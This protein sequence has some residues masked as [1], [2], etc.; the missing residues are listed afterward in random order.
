M[1][2]MIVKQ[3]DHIIWYENDELIKGYLESPKKLSEK[4]GVSP[5]EKL[6]LLKLIKKSMAD[7]AE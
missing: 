7:Q 4:K 2:D 3:K 6:S 1:E 5:A